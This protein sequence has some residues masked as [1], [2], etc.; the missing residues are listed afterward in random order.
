MTARHKGTLWAHN[1]KTSTE[2]A[3]VRRTIKRVKVPPSQG[4]EMMT[5]TS[6][7]A[8]TTPPSRRTK[9][10]MRLRRYFT[11]PLRQVADRSVHATHIVVSRGR[12]PR[13][14]ATR[15]HNVRLAIWLAGWH[16]EIYDELGEQLPRL[17]A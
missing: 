8:T 1:I 7:T 4:Y 9:R 2:G 16:I 12:F 17:S 3:L 14:I 13:A 11:R 5:M 6:L 15:D 10:D